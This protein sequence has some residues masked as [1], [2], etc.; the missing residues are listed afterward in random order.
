[1]EQLAL[2]LV[3]ERCAC[4]LYERYKWKNVELSQ[5]HN[6]CITDEFYSTGCEGPAV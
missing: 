5:N 1:M 3:I 4:L 2:I 6:S